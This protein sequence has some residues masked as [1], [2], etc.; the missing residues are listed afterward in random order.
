[1]KSAFSAGLKVIAG[2]LVGKLIDFFTLLVLAQFLVPT[3]FGLVAIA[4]SVLLIIEAL[5]EMPLLQPILRAETVTEDLYHTS[6]TLGV[7][8]AA[9]IFI[10]LGLIASP[11]ANFYDDNRLASLLLALM[12]APLARSLLSPKMAQYVRAYDM[13]PDMSMNIIS[14]L[15]SFMIVLVLAWVTGSYW[16]IAAGTISTPLLMVVISYFYAPY[17]PKFTLSQWPSFADIIGWNTLNQVFSAIGYQI[18][19]L[20]LG[21]V[22]ETQTMG[23]YSMA[24]ELTN[25]AFQGILVSLHQTRTVQISDA[26]RTKEVG[27]VYLGMLKVSFWIMGPVLLTLCFQGDA[28]VATLLGGDWIGTGPILSWLALSSLPVVFSTILTPVAIA[29]Y[30]PKAITIRTIIDVV[31]KIPLLIVGIYAFGLWGAVAAR[32]F[33]NLISGLIAFFASGKLT[34]LTISD[35]VVSFYPTLIAM[36]AFAIM[37]AIL[38]GYVD[39]LSYQGLERILLGGIIFLNFIVSLICQMAVLI[40]IWFIRGAPSDEVEYWLVKRIFRNLIP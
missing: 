9:L 16:A 31:I 28:I 36:M 37:S 34:K 35:Q 10:L 2:R 8:R 14:K 5:T 18:D 39:P 32:A 11:I 33:A 22:L 23:R 13:A 7:M 38:T 17:R 30:R 25:V 21:R 20:M 19:R 15:G 1:M 6:F 27:R 12:F 26:S 40:L 29:L 24:S 4:M 3:D